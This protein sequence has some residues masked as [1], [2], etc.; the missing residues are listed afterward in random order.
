MVRVTSC[1]SYLWLLVA[2]PSA[3]IAQSS[4]NTNPAVLDVAG[5]PLLPGVEYYVLPDTQRGATGGGLTLINRNESCPLYVG[6]HSRSSTGLPV[7][8]TPFFASETVIYEDADFTVQFAAVTIC[9]QSTQWE[10]D[11]S[12]LSNGSVLIRTGTDPLYLRIPTK[13]TDGD[14]YRLY[15]CPTTVCPICKYNCGNVTVVNEDGKRLLALYG[16]ALPVV[17]RRA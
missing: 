2:V 3:V 17:F 8:F 1:L 13:E 9:A 16:P 14:G 4:P 12:E 11:E 6:Q 7:I 15:F 10:L 5:Q